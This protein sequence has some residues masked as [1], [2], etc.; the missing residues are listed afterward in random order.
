M[1]EE[2]ALLSWHVENMKCA[3]ERVQKEVEKQ[4]RSS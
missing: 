3:V 1:K 4:E 2:N